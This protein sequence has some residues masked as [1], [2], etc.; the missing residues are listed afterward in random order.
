MKGSNICIHVPTAKVNMPVFKEC[1]KPI[2]TRLPNKVIELKQ[3]FF[4]KCAVF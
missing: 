3:H 4:V 2:P 1:D